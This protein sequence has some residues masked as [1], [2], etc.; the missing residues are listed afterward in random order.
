MKS[1]TNAAA[2]KSELLNIILREVNLVQ[3]YFIT[4]C[5]NLTVMKINPFQRG[6]VSHFFANLDF[7][8]KCKVS[9][10]RPQHNFM[11][12][13]FWSSELRRHHHRRHFACG[14]AAF[15]EQQRLCC[16]FFYGF[17]CCGNERALTMTV[18]DGNECFRLAGGKDRLSS[19]CSYLHHPSVEIE[20]DFI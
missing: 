13:L 11:K 2:I 5:L 20:S 18:D 15:W 12:K 8:Q 7:P 6:L 9:S 4:S 17:G 1:C 10:R 14:R 3:R 16:V 19:S